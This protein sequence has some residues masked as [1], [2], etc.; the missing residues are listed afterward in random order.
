MLPSGVINDDDDN[1]QCVYCAGLLM[2]M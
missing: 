2:M 1:S